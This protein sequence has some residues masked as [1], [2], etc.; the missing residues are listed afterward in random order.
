MDYDEDECVC[1]LGGQLLTDPVTLPSG[2]TVEREMILQVIKATGQN[3]YTR[4]A[5]SKDDLM[6]NAALKDK[7]ET[8]LA[9][10]EKAVSQQQANLSL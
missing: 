10:A 6:P 2:Q 4:K 3:P 5:L 9:D 7:I 8:L 1:P